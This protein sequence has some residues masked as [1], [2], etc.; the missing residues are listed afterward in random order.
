MMPLTSTAITYTWRQLAQR[1][2]LTGGDPAGNGFESL[3]IPVHYAHPEQV[4]LDQPGL[5]VVP[6][7]EIDWAKLLN[8]PLDSLDW[9]PIDKVMPPGVQPPFAGS[10]PVL[11]WGKQVDTENKKRFAYEREDGSVIF[12]ADIIAATFFMLS[13]WEETVVDVRDE[14][15]RFPASASVAYQQNFL[16]RPVVDEYALVL[17]AWL[18]LIL[19]NWQ[20]KLHQFSVKLSHDIDHIRRFLDGPTAFRALGRSLL[21]QFD[22]RNAWQICLDTVSQTIKPDQTPEIRGIEALAN[23]SIQYGFDSAFYFMTTKPGPRESDYTLTAPRMRQL[24][25][26][27]QTRGFEIGFHP[28]YFTLNNSTLLVNQKTQLDAIL[29]KTKYG[30]RQH[31]LRFRVPDTWRHWEQAGLVYDSTLGYADHEGFRCGTCHPFQPFDLEQDHQLELWELP[32][33][34]MDGTLKQ[35]RHLTPADGLEVV[36][37]LA[38][39]C[40]QVGGIFTLLWH[41]SS[42]YGDWFPWFVVYHNILNQLVVLKN[43]R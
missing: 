23:L 28:G 36:M 7:D 2:G 13:R 22:L 29:G 12:Y 39:K 30:G 38:R 4:Q 17:Q 35:Y 8:L 5:I 16:D 34:V 9:L 25:K 42:V 10:I 41:N 40:K 15:D 24:V 11:F 27:L 43:L 14:H 6:C 37:R 3:P 32:L 20:P 19:P 33:I 21:K 31:Y 1:A 26:N 18:H